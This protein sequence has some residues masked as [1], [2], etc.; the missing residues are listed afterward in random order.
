MTEAEYIVFRFLEE[1]PEVFYGRREIARKAVKRTLFEEDPNWANAPL[2]SL[3][4]QR[5]IEQ[6]DSGQY[7]YRKPSV[8][9]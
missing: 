9:G 4:A 5:L 3:V 7:R 6:N 8:A 1:S 2:S